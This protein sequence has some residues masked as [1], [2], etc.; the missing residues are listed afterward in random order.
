MMVRSNVQEITRIPTDLL[1]VWLDQADLKF[2]LN[3]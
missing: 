1:G 2:I 3:V